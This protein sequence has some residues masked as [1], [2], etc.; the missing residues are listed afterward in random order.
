MAL[1][2]CIVDVAGPAS[3][4]RIESLARHPALN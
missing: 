2:N 4:S 3:T 1:G